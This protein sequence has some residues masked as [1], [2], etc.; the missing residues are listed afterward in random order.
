MDDDFD[1]ITYKI[2]PDTNLS[3]YIGWPVVSRQKLE[4]IIEWFADNYPDADYVIMGKKEII[5][6][7]N[8]V[9]AHYKL[10]WG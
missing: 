9:A 8:K 4:N 10:V 7:D 3:G 2:T 6:K 5:I 1:G